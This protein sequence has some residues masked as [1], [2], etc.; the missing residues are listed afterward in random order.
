MRDL[1]RAWDIL[2]DGRPIHEVAL[3]L[4][5]A[6]AMLT[7]LWACACAFMLMEPLP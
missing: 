2:R 5:A 7:V 1:A 6:I 4:V 3:R